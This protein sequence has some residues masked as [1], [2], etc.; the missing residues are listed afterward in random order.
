MIYFLLACWGMTHIIVVSKIL[1]PI[2][3]YF[4]IKSPL[5]E[6]MLTCYQCS[7]FWVGLILY[8]FFSTIPNLT[9]YID[10]LIYGLISSGVCSFASSVFSMVNR[11]S[12]RDI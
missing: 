8:P 7:G 3:N 1:D 6:Y 10:P 9:T 12:K 2:R 4:I 5:M 11:I